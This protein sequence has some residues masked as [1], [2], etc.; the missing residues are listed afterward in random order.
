MVK[1]VW[2]PILI[3]SFLF[4]VVVVAS[5]FSST[6]FTVKDPVVSLGGA[7]GTSSNFVLQSSFGQEAIGISASDTFGVKSGFLYFPSPDTT[8]P[9]GPPTSSGGGFYGKPIIALRD[10]SVCDF[11]S[12]GRCNIFDLSIFL[13]WMDK[14]RDLASRFDPNQDGRLDVVDISLIFFYWTS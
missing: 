2:L 12:D 10:V 11:N 6:N 5:D 9:A 4:A 3:G 7:L 14:P 13:Y 1:N 8:L